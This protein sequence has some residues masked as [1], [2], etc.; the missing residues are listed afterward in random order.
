MM[1]VA[2]SLQPL[3]GGQAT[4]AS[5]RIRGDA[6]GM[7]GLPGPLLGPMVRRSVAGDLRRLKKIVE[8]GRG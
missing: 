4:Q 2:Y 5:I 3:D 8:G 1:D 6:R 7:Y